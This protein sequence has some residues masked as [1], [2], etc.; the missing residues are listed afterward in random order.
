MEIKISK[1]EQVTFLKIYNTKN[2]EVV[3]S[4]LGASFYDIKTPN[5]DGLVES[6]IL[7]PTSLDEFYNTDA[8]YGK[9]VGR[10]SGRIDKAKCIIENKEYILEKNWNGVNALHGCKYGISFVN[11]DYQVKECK[12]YID[13]IFTY[14]EKENILPGDVNYKITYRIFNEENKIKLFFE[15]TT[16]KTTIVNLTNHVYFNLSGNLKENCLNHNLQFN[17]DKYTRLNNELITESIDQVNEVFDFR[18]KH[19]LGKYIY[20]TSLQNHKAF[21][22][23]HCWLKEDLNNPLIAI[24]EDEKSGRKLSVSTSYPSVVCYAGCYPK[25]YLF[26]NRKNKIEQYHSVCLECQYIPNGIN[27]DNVDKALLKEGEI[28]S[29]YIEYLF[30]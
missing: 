8:Y 30:E 5:K 12:D 11:F 24:L 28:Y 3:L 10:F 23:D 14:L 4:T 17:A 25:K 21:G 20:D 7:T 22:Y 18:K 29:H 26:N 2:M 9:T 27:M 16:N 19:K 6:I 1:N 13:V 15:A